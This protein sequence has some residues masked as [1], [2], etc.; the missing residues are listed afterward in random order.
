MSSLINCTLE[1]ILASFTLPLGKPASS[2]WFSIVKIS[3]VISG[4]G[5]A[6]LLTP[7]GK[8]VSLLWDLS[9]TTYHRFRWYPTLANK[10]PAET[11][12]K[13]PSE[14]CVT[15]QKRLRRRV[16]CFPKSRINENGGK[17]QKTAIALQRYRH[18]KEN[19]P[20]APR[21]TRCGLGSNFVKCTEGRHELKRPLKIFCYHA[22][23]CTCFRRSVFY[24]DW[25]AY[26]SLYTCSPSADQV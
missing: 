3:R 22:L 10:A 23:A 8:V 26:I 13:F 4:F 12:Q 1:S 25:H 7:A 2:I 24:I 16:S 19:K 21:L 15:S 5:Q 6:F 11:F 20:L 18:A 17:W 14:R 9:G